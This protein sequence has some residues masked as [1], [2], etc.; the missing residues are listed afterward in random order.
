MLIINSRSIITKKQLI[1]RK[2]LQ[3]PLEVDS[4]DMSNLLLL[5]EIT[6][7]NDMEK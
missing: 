1:R 5:Q 2:F 7:W 4:E 3:L 6:I